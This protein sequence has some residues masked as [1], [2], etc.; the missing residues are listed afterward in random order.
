MKVTFLSKIVAITAL[1][2]S[3]Q[4]DAQVPEIPDITLPDIAMVR[5]INGQPVIVYNPQACQQAGPLLC[6]F[7]RAHEYCHIQLGHPIRQMWPQAQEFEAD[8][9][10]AKSVSNAEYASAFQWFASGGGSTPTHGS[11]QQRAV[12]IRA[13][14]FG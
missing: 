12:R 2:I 9:C 13:C 7:Y 10:A 14:R 5:V 4:A 8:C 11:G 6:G 3:T 1:L